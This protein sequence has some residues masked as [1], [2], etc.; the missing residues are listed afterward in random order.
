[1]TILKGLSIKIKKGETVALVGPSGCGKST[2][3][4]LIQRFYD[5]DT[6]YVS[7]SGQ[8]IKNIN[9]KKLREKIGVVGQE[10]VLFG[11]TIAENIK[12]VTLLHCFNTWQA[13]IATWD[14]L[15]AQAFFFNDCAAWTATGV[16]G[17]LSFWDF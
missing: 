16:A 11:C 15:L 1:M 12:Q 17:K 2:V 5:A 4:Q 3:I 6:G 13:S 9:L 14:F 8:D 10:P 7:F